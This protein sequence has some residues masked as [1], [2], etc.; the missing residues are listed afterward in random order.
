MNC[1]TSDNVCQDLQARRYCFYRQRHNVFD[2]TLTVNSLIL[3]ISLIEIKEKMSKLQTK[4]K[5]QNITVS[6]LLFQ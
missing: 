1:K 2:V 6:V 4:I 3:K 5:E